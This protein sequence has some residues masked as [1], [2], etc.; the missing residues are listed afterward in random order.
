MN[1]NID[2]QTILIKKILIIYLFTINQSKKENKNTI[3]LYV[4][5]I[6]II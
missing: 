4:I 3:D 5:I 6:N 2:L 1:N